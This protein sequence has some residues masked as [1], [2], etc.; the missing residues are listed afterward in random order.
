L[1]D[2]AYAD[3]GNDSE[4]LRALLQWLRIEPHVA[5]RGAPYS[6]GLG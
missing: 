6:S 3:R 1:P 4:P 5:R 2:E